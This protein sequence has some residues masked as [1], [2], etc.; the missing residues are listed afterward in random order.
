M[1]KL[2]VIMLGPSL[3]EKG[4]MGSVG[5][6]ILNTAPANLQ[7]QH[8]STWD[9]E[10]SRRS[11]LHRLKVFILAL[12]ALLWKLLRGEVD[13]V[14]IHLAERGSALRKSILVLIA[15][16]F[17]KP[18]I[19]HAHGCEFHSFHAT[20]SS[21]MKQVLNWVLQQSTYLIALS[22]SWKDYY[23]T[24]CHL[25]AEQVVVLPNPVEIPEN[26]PDR[27]N[28]H[29]NINFVFLGRIGKRKGAYDLLEAFAKLA[30]EHRE[31]ATLTL[32]GIGEVE[33][34]SN[35]AERL[36]IKQYLNFPGWVDPA[37]RSE[38]LFKADV[39]VLP[40]Y[41]EG[42]PMALLEAMSWGLPVITTP[43]GGI[44]EVVTD[45]ETGLL[46]NPG[47]VQQ[48]AEAVQSLI[49]H[50]SL[51]LDLG[52]AARRRVAP[53]DVKTYSRSLFNLYCSALGINKHWDAKPDL[54][55]AATTSRWQ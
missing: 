51:R 50:E 5:T 30:P 2:K 24:N 29:P 15:I 21:G 4:G 40:S 41:N 20:L 39:F 47:D 45:N 22:E 26:V 19:M 18:I 36:N 7:I 8:I 14:H 43:V 13:V 16:A 55:G 12:I 49:E 52:S 32:A 31:K 54:M 28:S 46:V 44:P 33:E 53:L 38:L 25:T 17:R 10:L 42:L 34:A 6:L 9:G 37:G 3:E 27:A 11:S 1:K 48:L 23:M 35:L